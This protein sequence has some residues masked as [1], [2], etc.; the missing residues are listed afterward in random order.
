MLKKIG[1]ILLWIGLTFVGLIALVLLVSAI[2]YP[3]DY[4]VRLRWLDADV[5]DFLKFPERRLEASSSTFYFDEE[6][7]EDRIRDLFETN[8]EIEELD[9]FLEETG[10]QAFIVIQDDNILYEK[11][12]NEAERDSIVTSFSMAKSFDSALIGATIEEGYIN[13]VDDPITDYLPELAER[14]P[15]FSEITI[16]DLLLMSSGIKYREFFFL[17][18]DDAKTYYYPDL[19]QLELEQTEIVDD[20][21]DYFLYNNYHPLLLGL[22]IERATGTSV[23]DYLQQKIWEPL[24]MEFDGSWSLD[25]E[26]SGFEK[27]E[28]GLNARAIDFAKFG[29]LYLNEGNW[30]GEQVIPAEW[31]AESTQADLSLDYDA[32]YPDS[33]IF[34]DGDGYYKYMWWGMN[35]GE[36]DYDFIAEGNHG[37]TIYVSPGKNLIIVRHAE[38]YGIPALDWVEMF[39]EFASDIE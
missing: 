24:G 36:G 8:P 3:M 2:I 33:F 37:Q 14:D 5:Y 20:P 13:S 29:R 9:T 27:M 7:D 30:E 17:N 22:I 31:V 15:A 26:D 12:F 28:S 21:G 39:Y 32:Y 4:F 16:R 19:R 34:G 23:T 35:R 25:S 18:G 10:T 11:Y 1:K 6:L 38:R